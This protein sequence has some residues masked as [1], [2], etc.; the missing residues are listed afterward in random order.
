MRLVAT[1]MRMRMRMLEESVCQHAWAYASIRQ[2]AAIMRM[3]I[4][5][6]AAPCSISWD[7]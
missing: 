3:R 6:C 2:D 4:L 7:S 1:S 5:L